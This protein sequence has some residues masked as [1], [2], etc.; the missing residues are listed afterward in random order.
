MRTV[1]YRPLGM[2]RAVLPT[3][4]LC[5]AASVNVT[6]TVEALK[7]C[8][9][10]VE[11][12]A[13]LLFTD[14][15]AVAVDPSIRV[16]RIERLRSASDYSY[17]VLKRLP[18][19]IETKHCLLVQ[20]DGFVI[21]GRV[22]TPA[23]LAFDY[24]GAPWPQFD[25]GL[26][27]GN[28]GF[29][30]RSRRLLQACADDRFHE[31]HPEDLS[32]CHANRSFLESEYEIRFADEA[33]ARKFAFERTLPSTPTFGFHG[34]FNLVPILGPDAFWELYRSLDDRST[35][36]P[37]YRL[38]IKQLSASPRALTRQAQL[39]VDLVKLILQRSLVGAGQA[40]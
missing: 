36:G 8:L 37:D 18:D 16:V 6:A 22:W 1:C 12:A 10:K 17:F 32:I 5:A 24:I 31:S 25:A 3:V 30:L 15:D 13:C 26:N 2:E 21:D 33:V 20:W 7:R 14:S 4:T 34:I 28:G 40:I 35:V 38:L 9:R 19:Y 27:V 39:T 23:F 29:S 11:V